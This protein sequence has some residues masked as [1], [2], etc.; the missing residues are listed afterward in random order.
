MAS[1]SGPKPTV[2]ARLTAL[3]EKLENLRGLMTNLDEFLQNL[4][5]E[6]GRRMEALE[7]DI[8]YTRSGL[9]EEIW[10][11]R[12]ELGKP[13]Q[14]HEE[15]MRNLEQQMEQLNKDGQK[16]KR[17]PKGKG[18]SSSEA[19][20]QARVLYKHLVKVRKGV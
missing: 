20:H 19:L 1:S 7:N 10:K 16:K 11:L 9:S 18:R 3:E 15:R 4:D 14:D 8:I 6:A 2:E 5:S 12:K 17:S 13:K